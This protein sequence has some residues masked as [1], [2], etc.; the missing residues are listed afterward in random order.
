[1]VLLTPVVLVIGKRKSGKAIPVYQTFFSDYSYPPD[2]YQGSML[3]KLTLAL[4]YIE[5]PYLPDIA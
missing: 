5:V 1:M 3:G 2:L 4:D